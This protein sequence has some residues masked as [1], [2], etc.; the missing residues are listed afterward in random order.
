MWLAMAGCIADN[1]IPDFTEDFIEQYPLLW[2]KK[3]LKNRRGWD[4][5]ESILQN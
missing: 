1:F 2:K 5:K 3:S 4:S